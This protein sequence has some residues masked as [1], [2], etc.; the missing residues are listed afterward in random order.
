M[1][2]DYFREIIE[3]QPDVSLEW[4]RLLREFGEGRWIDRIGDE[5]LKGIRHTD[6]ANIEKIMNSQQE[7]YVGSECIIIC[8][9]FLEEN[10][11]NRE[12]QNFGLV[13]LQGKYYD[14]R[15]NHTPEQTGNIQD[16]NKNIGYDHEYFKEDYDIIRE[17]RSEETFQY[18]F[19]NDEINDSES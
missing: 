15:C 13:S 5:V 9:E 19:G 12:I 6:T 4:I 7:I 18:Y 10:D 16:K 1:H 3:N 2:G 11:R 14:E 8:K 17:L